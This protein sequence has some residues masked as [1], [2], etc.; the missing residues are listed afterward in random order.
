MSAG[1]R[2]GCESEGPAL[3]HPSPCLLPS[4]MASFDHQLA[5]C[6]PF[7]PLVLAERGPELSVCCYFLAS[8][9]TWELWEG[10]GQTGGQEQTEGGGGGSSLS[11]GRSIFSLIVWNCQYEVVM[12]CRW[13]F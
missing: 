8:P 5:H 7:Q 11:W 9:P 4:G 10:G 13:T 3:C 12:K 1:V 2:D 6:A